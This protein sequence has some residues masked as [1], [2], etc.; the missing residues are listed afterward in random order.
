M[1]LPSTINVV[2]KFRMSTRLH[3]SSVGRLR[4]AFA[5]W[6]ER[7]A[8]SGKSQ[9]LGGFR[10]RECQRLVLDN[11]HRRLSKVVQITGQISIAGAPYGYRRDGWWF[12]S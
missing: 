10:P 1:E 4:S 11:R 2:F 9:V 3:R 5:T 8:V 7:V 12:G 6:P